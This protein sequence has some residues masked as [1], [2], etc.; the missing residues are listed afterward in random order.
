M[1]RISVFRDERG[2]S[3]LVATLLV[4]PIM[5]ALSFI[6]VPYFVYILQQNHL[7]TIASH[8][9]KESEV[10][11]SVTPSIMTSTRLKL[12]SVG[13]GALT[14]GGISYP[15]MVGSTTSKVKRDDADPMIRLVIKY[16]AANLSRLMTLL[17]GADDPSDGFYYIELYGRSEAYE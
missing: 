14:K 1:L 16:P 9:L 13:M 11:G 2:E 6:I 12:A 7:R 5:I 3:A 15:T 8:A 10:A 4:I 17:G